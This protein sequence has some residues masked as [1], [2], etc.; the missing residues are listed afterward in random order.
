[1]TFHF[2]ATPAAPEEPLIL[3]LCLEGLK[4]RVKHNILCNLRSAIKR[5]P[6]LDRTGPA[7]KKIPTMIEKVTHPFRFLEW[8]EIPGAPMGLR[9]A[10]DAISFEFEEALL[11]ELKGIPREE[12]GNGRSVQHFGKKYDFRKHILC[13]SMDEE[14]HSRM[15]P[16]LGLLTDRVIHAC[17]T[18]SPPSQPPTEMLG[19]HYLQGRGIK[20][21]V[22]AKVFGEKIWILSLLGET[23]I[24]FTHGKKEFRLQVPRRSMYSIQGEARSVWKHGI[25]GKDSPN[26]RVSLTYRSERNPTPSPVSLRY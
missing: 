10:F 17:G 5:G 23:V 19:N 1:M 26:P 12:V 16:C 20:E 25:E 11:K 2:F 13:D 14:I 8:D 7:Q 22:D 4:S 24:T 6:G 3:H 15:G 18:D 21:H 9:I